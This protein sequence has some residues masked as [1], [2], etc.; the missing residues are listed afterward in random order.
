MPPCLCKFKTLKTLARLAGWGWWMVTFN[1]AQ[2]YHHVLM[3]PNATHLLGFHVGTHWYQYQVLPFGLKC[4]P[5]V[6][7]KIVREMVA[8]WRWQG[9]IVMS[10][11][12]DFMVL[13]LS[14]VHV[15]VLCNQFIVT[16]LN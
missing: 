3:D 6:F 10:Y 15:I 4:A 5:W 14:H 7:T 11:I 16:L 8:I 2:G 1:L 12:D 13:V 9:I